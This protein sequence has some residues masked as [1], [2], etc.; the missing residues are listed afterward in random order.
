MIPDWFSLTAYLI[1]PAGFS[2]CILT[3]DLNVSSPCLGRLF[4]YLDWGILMPK[5]YEC[6]SSAFHSCSVLAY[7]F[8]ILL[9]GGFHLFTESQRSIAVGVS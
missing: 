3:C 6:S 7:V 2:H 4:V 5:L 9:G 8:F 1:Q